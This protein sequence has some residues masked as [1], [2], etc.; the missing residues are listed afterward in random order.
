M[1]YTKGKV[2][3]WAGEIGKG[4]RVGWFGKEGRWWWGGGKII[5][6]TDKKEAGIESS[7]FCFE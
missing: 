4:V 1:L 5:L 6:L 7:E 2:G 3:D